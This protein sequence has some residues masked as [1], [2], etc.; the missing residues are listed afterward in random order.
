MFVYYVL[1][2]LCIDFSG[3]SGIT[4]VIKNKSADKSSNA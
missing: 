1:Y 2:Q 4:A 3:V